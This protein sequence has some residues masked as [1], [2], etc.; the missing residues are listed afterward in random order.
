MSVPVAVVGAA[1]GLVS[2]VRWLRVSQREHYLPGQAVRT[3]RRWVTHRPPNAWLAAAAGTAAAAGLVLAVAGDGGDA[4][5][6]GLLLAAA[7]LG[8]AFPIGMHPLG[9]V[10]LKLTRR[11]SIQAGLG[12]VVTLAVLVLLGLAGGA[13][14]LALAPLV[15]LPAVDVAAAVQGPLERR[16]ARRFQA[17]AA[18]KLA[19]IRPTVVAITGSYGKTT[20]KNHVH[21]LLASSFTTVASPASWN[22]QAGLSRAINEHVA[23]DTEVFVAEMGTYGPGEIAAMVGWVHPQVAIIAALGPVHLE[24]MGTLESIARAKA[25]I[26]PG[27]EVAILC[28]DHPLLDELADTV[29]GGAGTLWRVGTDP[30]R[31]DLDVVVTTDG[32]PRLGAAGA[33]GAAPGPAGAAGSAE[34][35]YD[36]VGETPGHDPTPRAAPDGTTTTTTAT[37]DGDV[38]GGND[39]GERELVV[40]VRGE[41]LARLPAGAL[42]PGNV[43]CAVAAALAVGAAPKSVAAALPRLGPPPNRAVPLTT[44]DGLTVVDDTFNSNPAGAAAAFA[45]LQRLAPDGRHVVVTPGMV[46]LGD[47]QFPANRTFAQAVAAAGADLLVVG[48]TNRSALVDG[49]PRAHLVAD[50][51]AAREWVRANLGPGDAVLWENDLPDH[52]P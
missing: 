9:A 27:A 16:L 15:A 48:W 49:H 17:Q 31:D 6:A 5:P 21:D 3:A 29:T 41:E 46:E 26:L 36:V 47:D 45:N 8:A 14:L 2:L 51:A 19:R 12:L 43:A 30:G 39:E 13:A 11:A 37:T 35:P 52:Y 23:P 18:T 20:V 38:D 42:Q 44:E 33:A 7:V 50:R 22:N 28:V 24:R 4:L 25:E 1:A 10:R 34:G 40:T 32:D